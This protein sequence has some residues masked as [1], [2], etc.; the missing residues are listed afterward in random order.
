MNHCPNYKRIYKDLIEQK[1]PEKA[2]KCKSL[3]EKNDFSVL[4]VIKINRLL[5][6][7]KNYDDYNQKYRSYNKSA[8]LEMLWYQKE[9]NLNNTQLASHF[10]LSRNTVAKW[11]KSFWITTR[12][13]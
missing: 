10:K 4:D 7:D 8:I 3:L 11:K 1:Y 9:H 2:E 13:A 5:L 12:G 6:D